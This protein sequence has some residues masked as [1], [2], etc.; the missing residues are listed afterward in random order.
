MQ[1]TYKLIL[2]YDLQMRSDLRD[3]ARV[4]F[5]TMPFSDLL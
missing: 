4:A 2:T 1:V 3:D 5:A